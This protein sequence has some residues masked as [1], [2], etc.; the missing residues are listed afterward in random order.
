MRPGHSNERLAKVTTSAKLTI[1]TSKSKNHHVG[2]DI[3]PSNPGESAVPGDGVPGKVYGPT[4]M[5][6][7]LK[8]EGTRTG[9]STRLFT[10]K[11]SVRQSPKPKKNG[12]RE[13][14]GKI[15]IRVELPNGIIRELGSFN[16][17][18]QGATLRSKIH[19]LEGLKPDLIRLFIGG[20]ELRD[21]MLL[22]LR[23]GLVREE[24]V[25]VSLRCLGGMDDKYVNTSFLNSR[26]QLTI[27]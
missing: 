23:S 21:D 27:E 9:M 10:R 2:G 15:N 6:V 8:A 26:L 24:R 19:D 22:S 17:S 13:E 4:S 20:K 12:R 3:G 11:L 7:S 5:A 25:R 18:D 14:S 1:P 16:R